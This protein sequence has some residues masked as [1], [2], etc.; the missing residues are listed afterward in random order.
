[1]KGLVQAARGGSDLHMGLTV[2]G[3][4]RLAAQSDLR[5]GRRFSNLSRG[6]VLSINS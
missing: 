3:Y 2:G 6:G 5:G 1:M 4:Y